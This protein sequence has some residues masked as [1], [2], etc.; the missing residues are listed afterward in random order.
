MMSKQDGFEFGEYHFHDANMHSRFQLGEK[1][2]GE[3]P[4]ED[5]EKYYQM[6]K[7]GYDTLFGQLEAAHS[8]V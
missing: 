6:L 1:P 3:Y 2:L 5:R 8:K 7:E 4:D